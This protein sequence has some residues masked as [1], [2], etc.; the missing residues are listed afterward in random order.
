M[1]IGLSGR[2]LR[3]IKQKNPC[4]SPHILKLIAYMKGINLTKIFTVVFLNIWF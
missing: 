1:G 2:K 4:I 3:T